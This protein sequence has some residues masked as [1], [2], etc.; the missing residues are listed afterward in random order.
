MADRLYAIALEGDNVI[1]PYEVINTL[2]GKY[3]DIPVK[4]DTLSLPYAFRHESPFPETPAIE[5][6]VSGAFDLIFKR[7]TDWLR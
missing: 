3:H 6:E 1:Y 4:V 5:M 7:V 2:R